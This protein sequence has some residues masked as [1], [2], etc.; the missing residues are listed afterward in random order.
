MC[1]RIEQIVNDLSNVQVHEFNDGLKDEILGE[2]SQYVDVE[3][4]LKTLTE[5]GISRTEELKRH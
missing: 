1:E 5:I 4:V 3:D 2:L